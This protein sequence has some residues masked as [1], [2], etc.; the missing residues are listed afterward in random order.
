MCSPG[1]IIVKSHSIGGSSVALS[2]QYSFHTRFYLLCEDPCGSNNGGCS[3]LC[4]LSA[5]A[6]AGY[7]CV[8]PDGIDPAECTG[9]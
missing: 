1:P 7:S 4:L 6:A 2:V 3:H 5:A 9:K 8:C